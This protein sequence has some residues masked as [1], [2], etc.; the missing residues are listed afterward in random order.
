M[1]SKAAHLG[2]EWQGTG[3]TDVGKVRL[4]NQDAF[5]VLDGIRLW[6]VADG[7]S[8]YGGG[9]IASR[10]AVAT[11]TSVFQDGRA[12][13]A[14]SDDR[15]DF[16]REGI[17]AAHQ[18]IRSEAR[19]RPELR[20]MGTTVVAVMLTPGPPD[21]LTVAHVGDSRAYLVRGRGLTQLTQ[22]HTA[23]RD[24]VRR[25]LLSEEEALTHPERHVLMRAL[26]VEGQ[27][28]PDLSLHELREG[29]QILLCTDGL[30]AMLADWE[31]LDTILRVGSP[32]EAVCRALIDAANRR[33]GRD[34]ITVVLL[35]QEP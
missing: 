14:G 26:G 20:R 34:N 22:D 6:I 2:R 35:R 3:L 12:Q 28:E 25:G 29:D 13:E 16:L 32:A 1:K 4:T 24:Y 7:M 23:V 15:K 5:A 10:L 30:T 9:E 21:V 11:L 33:G 17:V 18:A 31:I 27:A 8:G 19:G